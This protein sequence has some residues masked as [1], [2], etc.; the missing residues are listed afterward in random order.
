MDTEPLL[1]S[2]GLFAGE[3]A[4]R[5]WAFCAGQ[6]LPIGQNQ[7]LYSII[8]N[9]FGGDGESTFTLPDL[10]GKEPIEGL[11][12]CIALVGIIPSYI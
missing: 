5:G 11:H 3:K 9:K 6:F 12:Y 10:R 1:G 2:I 8:G 7:A 4:P